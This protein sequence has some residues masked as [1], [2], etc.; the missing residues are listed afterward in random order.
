MRGRAEAILHWSLSGK[1]LHRLWTDITFLV[2]LPIT[3]TQSSSW[4]MVWTETGC[5]I[6]NAALMHRVLTKGSYIGV[7]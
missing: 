4:I 1:A 6:C 7:S 5:I 2:T 3:M